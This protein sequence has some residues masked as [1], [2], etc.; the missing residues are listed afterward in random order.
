MLPVRGH[1][2]K[3]PRLRDCQCSHVEMSVARTRAFTQIAN[4]NNKI[5]TIVEMS[6]AR[7]RAFTQ[8]SLFIN[9]TICYR[10]NE[11]CPYEGIYTYFCHMWPFLRVPSR[12]EC[13][14]YE[15]IYTSLNWNVACNFWV[16]MSV[17][18]TRAFTRW[19]LASLSCIQKVEMSVART[20]AFTPMCMWK[21]SNI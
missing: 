12:N 18:R 8:S 19:T 7:T 17:A 16:E 10:R 14:P 1:L 20:R 6:V 2:H 11:C 5:A 9:T 15:G 4:A 3:A 13:C 21:F